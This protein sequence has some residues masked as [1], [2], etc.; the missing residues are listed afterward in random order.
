MVRALNSLVLGLLGCYA[1]IAQNPSYNFQKLGL[2]EGLHDGTTRCIAQ[3]KFGYIWMG[4]VGALNRFDGKNVV[5]FTYSQL[6]KTTPYSSQPRA[7]HSDAGGRLW[8]GYETGLVEFN[9]EK[10]NFSRVGALEGYY[11]S[12]IESLGDSVLLLA[13]RSGLIKY[14]TKTGVVRQFGGSQKPDHKIL[15]NSAF[16]DVAL[17]NNKLYLAGIR[18]LVVYDLVGD[19]TFSM[20]IPPL[21][22][23]RVTSVA[24]DAQNNVWLG[25]YEQIKLVRLS[26][27]LRSI[28]IYDRFLTSDIA[29]QPLNVMDIQVDKNNTVW[30]ATAIDGLLQY[31]PDK[32]AFIRHLHHPSIPSSPAGNNYRCLFQDRDNVI[33][34]GCDFWGVN[35]FEPDRNLF[36]TILP[37]PNR[38]D[39]RERGV[40][41]A[42]AEDNNGLLWIGNHDGVSSYNPAT[43]TYREWRNVEGGKNVLYNNVVRSILCDK[44]NNIWIGTGSGVNRYN[45]AT[46][47]M[48]FISPQQ[49]PWSFYNSINEDRDGKIW[50]CTNDTSTLYRYDPK[51]KK[52]D[53]ICHHPQLKVFCGLTPTSYVL[54]DTKGR[55]WISLS[56]QGLGMWNKRTGEVKQYKIPQQGKPGIPG[57]Q[58]VDIKEDKDGVIWLTSFNGVCGLDAERDSFLVFDNKNGLPG[59]RTSPLAIDSLN[60][61]WIGVNGGLMMIDS[62][63]KQLIKFT[64]GDGLPFTGFPEHAGVV[65]KDGRFIFPT[66]RGY[67]RFNPL[68]YKGTDKKLQFYLADY[69]VFDKKFLAPSQT[70]NNT[71]TIE[72]SHDENSFTFNLIALNFINP[73]QTWYAYKLEG[74]EKEWHYTQDPK[75]VYTN[76]PGG[77]YTFL[78]KAA[79][80]QNN[81]DAIAPKKLQVHLDAVFYR[82]VWFWMIII[83]LIAVALYLFY[84]YRLHQQAQIIN[85]ETKAEALEKEKTMIQYESLKQ[86]LNPHF[87]FNSLTSL[88]SLIKTDSKTAAW[89]L[90]GLSKVYRYVLKSAEKELVLLKEEADF[91]KTFCEMQKVRFGK[92]FEIIINIDDKEGERYIAPVVLQNLVENAIKHNTTSTDEPLVIEIFTESDFI[93]VRNN[94]QR[95]RVVETSNKQ[96]L[97]SL[98]K[99][100]S[101]YTERTII[102]EEDEQYF[103]VKIPLL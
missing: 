66:Y 14:F 5:H 7:I 35:F 8:I 1:A 90:D 23:M 51:T 82:T 22:D 102:I 31:L 89:F 27:D 54:E 62:D 100:Y 93:T 86:H 88:R 83:V 46:G 65:L 13:T 79:M 77:D 45:A 48:E 44:E 75:A 70:K 38:L 4:T 34:M 26:A 101:F 17:R 63:R 58:I 71:G 87:L 40:G 33:W 52:F 39:E 85:L 50:F 56:R 103:V 73:H 25:T 97:E 78:Y 47:Q 24:L 61:V 91:V 99:L 68:A 80:D 16:Y 37:H 76:V 21:Y 98:R 59:N 96:G 69:S 6:D 20:P 43:G 15:A 9:F 12:A 2:Q 19:T 92:G 18:G 30:V 60:R 49:L 10:A 41:R 32:D 74:F 81:W 28:N 29:T 84:R 57:N 3:D 67:I 11:V 53:N 95:Y 64:T 55:I 36:E 94:L 72:L 42:I